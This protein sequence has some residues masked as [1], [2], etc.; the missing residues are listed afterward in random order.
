MGCPFLSSLFALFSVSHQKFV[1]RFKPCNLFPYHRPQHWPNCRRI[2]LTVVGVIK[3]Q[4]HITLHQ[5]H[6]QSLPQPLTFSN[7]LF[8]TP[9]TKWPFTVKKGFATTVMK[10]G[11][12][13]HKCQGRILLLISE[14]D[15]SENNLDP[16]HQNHQIPLSCPRHH[17]LSRILAF[18]HFLVCLHLRPFK[19]MGL[20][21]RLASLSSWTV[22]APIAF[23][24][25]ILPNSWHYP[26]RRF[27][28]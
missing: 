9:R 11:T 1:K 10:N 5:V 24:N 22:A 15:D 21:A 27:H 20:F 4:H 17:N 14:P 18:M 19:F 7:L 26:W 13:P 6:P 3:P 25:L 8:I 28:H 2:S 12:C 23:S 16:H